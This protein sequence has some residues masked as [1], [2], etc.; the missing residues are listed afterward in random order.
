VFERLSDRA[1]SIVFIVLTL[2]IALVTPNIAGGLILAFSPLL[3]AMVMLLVI[4][5][6]GYSREGWRR[7]GIGRLG[8]RTW[9][10]AIATTAGVCLLA[11][12]A[13]VA[14][15]LPVSPRHATAGYKTF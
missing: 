2:A 15:A 1:A 14:L 10:L 9:P 12:A 7:L 13:C 5:R 4:T 8:L 11:A 6:E 3:V